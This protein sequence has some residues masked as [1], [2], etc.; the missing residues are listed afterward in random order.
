MLLNLKY[1][2]TVDKQ[3][4]KLSAVDYQ[5]EEIFCGEQI[6]P[7]RISNMVFNKVS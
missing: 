6:F 7:C 2:V 5:L 1:I 4:G 3:V